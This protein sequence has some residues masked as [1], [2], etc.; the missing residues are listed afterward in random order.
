MTHAALTACLHA[1]TP[2]APCGTVADWWPQWL[3]L[4]A[5]A[6]P[7]TL[8]LLGGLAADRVGW[9]FAA[10]YQAALRALRPALPRSTM[11]ALCVTE[12]GGNRPRDVLTT[13]TPL[14]DGRV[15]VDGAKRWT[16]LGPAAT[17][18]LVVGR[19]AGPMP[20]GRSC[21]WRWCPAA[22]RAWRCSRCPGWPWC[23]RCRTRR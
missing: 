20:N 9:A 19:R 22:R 4:P 8:A 21:R 15:R 3:A 14:P 10:G 5:D 23:P 2:P 16:T 17:L 13:I 7:A 1:A 11:A 6:D 12:A 18:L